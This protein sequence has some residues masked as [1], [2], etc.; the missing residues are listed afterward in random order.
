MER[1]AKAERGRGRL[2]A[3]CGLALAVLGG[4]ATKAPPA[5]PSTQ[6]VTRPTAAASSSP[7]PPV[8]ELLSLHRSRAQTSQSGLRVTLQS[9]TI[10]DVVADP[11]SG[12]PGYGVLI[13]TLELSAAGA[14]Q[15]VEIVSPVTP[16]PAQP[17]TFGAYR[18]SFVSSAAE[19]SKDP[20]IVVRVERTGSLAEALPVSSPPV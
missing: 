13:A 6:P 18:V 1:R 10:E 2:R 9:F 15:T 3:T 17:V 20:V 19:Y 4:C 8:E 7:R 11:Q 16:H 12:L 14:S 5:A